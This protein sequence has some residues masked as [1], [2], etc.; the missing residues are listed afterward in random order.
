MFLQHCLIQVLLSVAA[1]PSTEVLYAPEKDIEVSKNAIVSEERALFYEHIG[2]YS[3][4]LAGLI[5]LL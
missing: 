1:S 2:E 4:F 5:P 3:I